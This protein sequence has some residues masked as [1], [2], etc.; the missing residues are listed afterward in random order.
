MNEAARLSDVYRGY[1]GADVLKGLDLEIRRGETLALL[2]PNGSG[3][4][5]TV[6]LL[7][8]LL[9][10][11][12]GS[13]RLLGCDPRQRVAR[14]RCGAML[15]VG[16]VPESLTVREHLATFRSYYPAP[17]LME[18]LLHV[19]GLEG[20]ED[21]PYG[22][23]SGG[24]QQRV[25]LGL[26]LSGNPELL[27]L[28]EPTTGLDVEARR[29]MWASID[30]S[31]ARG[32]SI[33]LTTHNLR[34]AEEVSDRVVVLHD[35]GAVDLGSP[36]QARLRS[37]TRIITCRTSIAS[38][39]ITRMQGVVA[40]VQLDDG[41]V[42]LEVTHVEDVLRLMFASEGAIEDLEITTPSLEDAYLALSSSSRS[43]A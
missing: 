1:R 13:V 35:G 43:V 8:G 20:L 41:R 24:Q 34:E 12:R 2:G 17:M 25:L 19:A 32:R 3:K 40:C 39:R 29:R 30:Q 36:A 14:Q 33:L 7:L 18:E 6:R 11:D 37:S 21:R 27:I 26:A 5:T 16:K 22:R 23:L 28:D 42:R 9:S 15:Q 38:S 4:T 31:R 10:P